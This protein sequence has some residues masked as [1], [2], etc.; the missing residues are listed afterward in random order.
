LLRG[1]D[2]ASLETYL[3]GLEG[4]LAQTLADY[5]SLVLSLNESRD[6]LQGFY[7]TNSTL[8]E[9]INASAREH[10][11]IAMDMPNQG[12]LGD[13]EKAALD[14][15]KDVASLWEHINRT[16][17]A[18]AVRKTDQNNAFLGFLC[19]ITA[20]CYPGFSYGTLQSAC[21]ETAWINGMK[22]NLSNAT[23]SCAKQVIADMMQNTTSNLSC[24][25]TRDDLVHALWKTSPEECR[26]IDASLDLREH[27][28]NLHSMYARIVDPIPDIPEPKPR[29]CVF[30]IC[31]D[32]QE[33]EYPVVFLHGHSPIKGVSYEYSLEVFNKLQEKLEEDGYLNA[34]EIS[35]YTQ[36]DAESGEWG[37]SGVPVT[38]RASYYV[39]RFLGGSNYILVQHKT[40]SIDAYAVR[41][42]EI[43][44]IIRYKTGHDKARIV[45]FS[46]GGLVAR[47]YVH[48]FGTNSVECLILVG[49]PNHG[50]H[51]RVAQLCPVVGEKLECR[52]LAKDSVMLKKLNSDDLPGIPITNIVGRGC[53]MSGEDGDGIVTRKSAYLDGAANHYIDGVCR[54]ATKSLHTDLLDIERYPDVY[55]IISDAL[56]E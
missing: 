8:H 40:E 31:S 42:K 45:A 24:N 47:R 54:S 36:T 53:D 13:K 27:G 18:E 30:N 17:T 14:L 21:N 43:M 16:N 41:L 25:Y 51:G 46:M 19:N 11:R 6:A 39:D 3:A 55:T 7:I 32:C 29:C 50:V 22:V 4:Q 2:T 1:I 20:E 52:D 35:V 23:D 26:P 48:L 38:L 56:S 37:K 12:L 9:M 33:G 34:G 28:L 10:N 15:R 44:D 5:N 49:S